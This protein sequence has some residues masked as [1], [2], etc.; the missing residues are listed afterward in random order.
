MADDDGWSKLNAE[1]REI[2][3]AA[4]ELK[5]IV[6]TKGWETYKAL[7]QQIAGAHER[8]LFMSISEVKPA[9]IGSLQGMSIPEVWDFE[10]RVAKLELIKGVL[11][12]LRLALSLPETIMQQS[13]EINAA[14]SATKKGI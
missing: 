1:E 9:D 7:V 11:K 6:G 8:I 13:S 4:R 10:T 14:T 5:D 3:R 12:G 2:L